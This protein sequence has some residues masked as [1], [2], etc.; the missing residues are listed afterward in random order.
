MNLNNDF[1]HQPLESTVYK[2]NYSREYE[3]GNGWASEK[4][5][6]IVDVKEFY[7]YLIKNENQVDTKLFG[8]VYDEVI[9]ICKSVIQNGNKLYLIADD[10]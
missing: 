10:F 7:N 6:L 2:Y 9:N 8:K 4:E 1:L 5:E 3:M